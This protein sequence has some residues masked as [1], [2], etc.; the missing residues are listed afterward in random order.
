MFN[1]REW[2]KNDVH[3]PLPK[4]R[5]V[6]QLFADAR[7]VSEAK[8]PL[9][10]QE[11]DPEGKS[12][13]L[14]GMSKEGNP[15][16]P[17]GKWRIKDEKVPFQSGFLRDQ[18]D[19]ARFS[20]SSPENLASA[21]IFVLLTIRADFQQVMHD[22]PTVMAMLHT[23]GDKLKTAADLSNAA[24]DMHVRL[25]Q[26]VSPEIFDK[27]DYA[28][29]Y[30][31][32]S[33]LFGFKN[34]G[35][36]ETWANRE[37]IFDEMRNFFD[38]NDAVGMFKYLLN[39][40]KG[41]KP[42]KAGFVVQIVMG[43]LGC[44]DMHNINLYSH[45]ATVYGKKQLYDDLDPSKYGGRG[46]KAIDHYLSVL[47]QLANEGAE[48]MKLWDIWTNYVAHNYVSK[49][50]G[51]PTYDRSSAFAGHSID[52]NDPLQQKLKAMGTIPNR[53]G[54]GS[55]MDATYDVADEIGANT[56]SQAHRIISQVRNKQFYYDL[57]KQAEENRGEE[58]PFRTGAGSPQSG[59]PDE[60]RISTVRRPNKVLAYLVANPD[61]A[62]DIGLDKDFLDRAREVMEKSGVF[63]GKNY[64]S[65]GKQSLL[66]TP[67][68]L[69]SG[70]IPVRTKGPSKPKKKK[71]DDEK[72]DDSSLFD[73]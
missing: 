67:E 17:Y 40:V 44:I 29:G 66:W 45:Y 6:R 38:K 34:D 3:I 46:K 30:S 23:Q 64:L 25:S 60:V 2:L 35:I 11:L 73:F 63:P 31:L 1:F 71:G 12:V 47:D 20:M 69:G 24:E 15:L 56:G 59:V 10:T 70:H 19:I 51:R 28:G 52:P 53:K 22:F 55:N 5:H 48:T 54:A 39:T 50:T 62:K 4:P 18:P 16:I 43:K 27:D 33:T 72:K 61:M 58:T 32:K 14:P 21:I 68:P 41:L 9:I 36:A 49:K 57:L 7:L 65:G 26:Q 8:D 42:V 37:R 13:L